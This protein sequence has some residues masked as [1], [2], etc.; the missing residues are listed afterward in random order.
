VGGYLKVLKGLEWL[1]DMGYESK[2][3]DGP[4][5]LLITLKH[6]LEYWLLKFLPKK[7][8]YFK[9][10]KYS[11]FY[12]PYNAT[13]IMERKVEIPI[14][15]EIVKK[16]KGKILEVG[17]VLPH[18]MKVKHKVIDKYE[19][20]PTSELIDILDYEPPQKF[21]LIISIST[22][23]HVGKDESDKDSSKPLKAIKHLLSLLKKDGRLIISYP[24]WYNPALEKAV[25]EVKVEKV[26]N[27]LHV[28]NLSP[29][30]KRYLKEVYIIEFY[31]R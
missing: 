23:E 10:K 7:F 14:F 4:N 21:D 5:K 28:K 8:F 18:Y 3:D 22:L 25:S 2:R 27:S 31:N 17:C 26:V 13:W 1:N 19:L 6:H 9:G 11:Y 24:K 29:F 12:H 16:S 15:K 30:G 20:H